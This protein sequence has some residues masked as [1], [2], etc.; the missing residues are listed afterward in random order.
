MK[1]YNDCIPCI[2]RG[3]LDA[4]RLATNDETLQQ[5]VVKE[6]LKILLTFDL[7]NPPPLMAQHIQQTV[8][9]MTGNEDP[10][11]AIKKK[12]NDFALS[13]YD[14]LKSIVA[15]SSNPFET[16]T[17]LAIAGNIID[18]GTSNSVGKQKI[19]KTIEDSISGNI[20]GDINRFETC[21]KKAGKILY[22]ADNAGEIV[23]DQLLLEQIGKEKAIFVVRKGYALNDAT[24]KDA[25]STGISKDLRVIDNGTSI[26]GT[27]LK[28]CSKK[29]LAEYE[30]ADLII[31]KGQG[32]YETLEHDDKRVFFLLKIKCSIV[33]KHSGF[34]LNDTV[35]Y[36]P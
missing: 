28:L 23:F 2:V 31:S 20:I 11:K 6:I 35:I 8:K 13:I 36:N 33:S 5:K 7:N 17:R 24:M 21:V 30:R 34:N 14:E 16:A 9:K 18:Y 4:A 10:Y 15:R 25:V 3:S 12:Y 29:F 22:L 27:Y 19:L 32:N 1:L 26:P